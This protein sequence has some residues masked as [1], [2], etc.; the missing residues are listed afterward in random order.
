MKVRIR[1]II[2]SLL[3]FVI[4]MSGDFIM[5]AALHKREV[6][7]IK[8]RSQLNAQI[9]GNAIKNQIIRAKDLTRIIQYAVIAG[10]GNVE[11]FD[12]IAK[13]WIDNNKYVLNVELA[14]KGVVTHVY[15]KRSYVKG[16]I[17]LLNDSDS[18]ALCK[19]SIKNDSTTIQGP[20]KLK[21]GGYGYALR[22]PVM[23]IKNGKKT[24]W[25]FAIVI[26][27]A[28]K[29]IAHYSDSLLA[30]HY[31]LNL[32]Q[33]NIY[34]RKYKIIGGEKKKLAEVST[35]QFSFAHCHWKLCVV[36][37]N[38]YVVS[39]SVRMIYIL[40][41]SVILLLSYLIYIMLMKQEQQ[42]KDRKQAIT[43]YLTGLLNRNGFD[44]S[45]KGYLKIHKNVEACMIMLDIDDFKFV[46][47]LHGHRVGDL[48]LKNLAKRLVDEFGS[49]S[50]IGRNGGDEF[51]VFIKHIQ[52][53]QLVSRLD[54]FAAQTYRVYDQ[55]Q[56]IH[57]TISLGYALYPSQAQEFK[58]L[59]MRAD[60]SLYFMKL[61]QKKG[62]AQYQ[63]GM[64]EIKRERLG[65]NLNNIALHLPGAFIIYSLKENGRILF[66]NNEMIQIMGCANDEEF[67]EY[68]H[69]SVFSLVEDR[70]RVEK[71][72]CD[73]LYDKYNNKE[74][75]LSFHVISKDGKRL[76]IHERARLVYNDF[77]GDIVYATLIS[78][79]EQE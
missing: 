47:D 53:N 29:M 69:N 75:R 17:D 33:K 36:P 15:P 52:N 37:E 28:D 76:Y 27:D 23:F 63:D 51:C 70:E 30:L 44:E 61:N 79:Q 64:L 32:Y 34:D 43:D 41:F 55:G 68:S 67:L 56:M 59:I 45:V 2:I 78:K 31:R 60:A 62:A 10:N 26:I 19:Y 49:D 18:A 74:T 22:N 24:F 39:E 40:F 54:K 46:N 58:S 8:T 7:T 25:G 35:Y 77:F 14:P 6:D 16:K 48:V 66:A 12:H 57:Y 21:Q 4:G 20:F 73:Q 13:K 38:G 1:N 5:S 65:F 3:I 9:Y 50:I 42:K 11:D 72:L 71:E